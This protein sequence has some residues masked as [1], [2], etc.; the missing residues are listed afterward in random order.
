MRQNIKLIALFAFMTIAFTSCEEEGYADYDPGQTNVK[1]VSGEWY[2]KFLVDGEDIYGIGYTLLDTY[3]TAANSSDTMWIN[4]NMNTWVYKVKVPVNI[5]A[6]TFSGNDLESSIDDDD[7]PVTPNYEVTVNI[8]EG[9]VLKGAAT[10]AAGN[11]TDSI[12][13]KAVFSDDPGTIYQIAGFKRTGFEEDE[14]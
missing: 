6:K 12:H 10:T 4:D 7:D 1:E 9:K 13:F 3:N 8:S 14:H 2:V 5:D 11:V